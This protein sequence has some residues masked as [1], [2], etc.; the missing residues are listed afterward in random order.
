MPL[1][2][3]GPVSV[4]SIKDYLYTQ[5]KTTTVDK[6]STDAKASTTGA[7]SNR[8]LFSEY[9]GPLLRIRRGSENAVIDFYGDFKGKLGTMAL[10]RGTSLAKWLNGAPGFVTIMYAQ[11]GHTRHLRQ[12]P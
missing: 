5:E 10:G 9:P 11:C 4:G 3:N 7:W 6:L 8:L 1:P 12:P 2:A